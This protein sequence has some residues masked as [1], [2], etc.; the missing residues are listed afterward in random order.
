MEHVFQNTEL[1]GSSKARVVGSEA[2]LSR[3]LPVG[4]NTPKC[5]VKPEQFSYKGLVLYR[6]ELQT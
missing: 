4:L 1:Q 2:Y 6:V 5:E 3:L